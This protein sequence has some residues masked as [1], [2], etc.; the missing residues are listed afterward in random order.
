LGRDHTDLA[1]DDVG[2]TFRRNVT[3]EI[4]EVALPLYAK[5]CYTMVSD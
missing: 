1:P 4:S 2:V 3:L 5:A